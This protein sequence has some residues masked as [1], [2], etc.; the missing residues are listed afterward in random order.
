[1]V[2]DFFFDDIHRDPRKAGG[3]YVKIRDRVKRV[4]T[5]NRIVELMIVEGVI[6][7]AIKIDDI[8]DI[9]IH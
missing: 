9:K 1:M 4:D 8:M 5:V 6:N 2:V 7:R 3:K